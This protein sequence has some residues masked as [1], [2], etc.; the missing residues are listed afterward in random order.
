MTWFIIIQFLI[1]SISIVIGFKVGTKYGYRIGYDD[2]R[3]N[4][5]RELDELN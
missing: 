2:G 1:A 5:D 3:T 4:R